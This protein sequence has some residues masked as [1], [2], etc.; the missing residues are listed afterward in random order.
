MI[1]LPTDFEGGA[2][3]DAGAAGDDASSVLFLG[4]FL[5]ALLLGAVAYATLAW[6]SHEQKNKLLKIRQRKYAH[7]KKAADK[8][9]GA[10]ADAEQQAAVLFETC[11][12]HLP[13]AT[14]EHDK[15]LAALKKAAEGADIEPQRLKVA[16]IER[17]RML[18]PPRAG[19]PH[20]Q[21]A[22]VY[23]VD[24][25]PAPVP[26]REQRRER[27]IKAIK[28]FHEYWVKDAN[29]ADMSSPR[30]EELH[31]LQKSFAVDLPTDP[32]AAT[33]LIGAKPVPLQTETA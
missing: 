6:A 8:A 16:K 25:D 4:L 31:R 30:L 7:I 18:E 21:S 17:S 23:V 15:I 29:G 27:A 28:G 13:Q 22:E 2:W 1:T 5:L 10:S 24:E 3:A 12:K 14:A 9:K 33:A 32:D 20:P 19:Y 26:G 11:R